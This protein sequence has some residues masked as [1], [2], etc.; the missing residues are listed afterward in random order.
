MGGVALGPVKNQCPSVEECLDRGMGVGGLL[1]RGRGD[2][3]VGFQRG[4]Q[5]RG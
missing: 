5:E 2:E 1:G 3:I 4:N